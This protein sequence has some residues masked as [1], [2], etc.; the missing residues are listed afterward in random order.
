MRGLL[1]NFYIVEDSDLATTNQTP[2]LF[3][4]GHCLRRS[5][6]LSR[7]KAQTNEVCLS[8]KDAK[9]PRED[10]F[11][12]KDENCRYEHFNWGSGK[13]DLKLMCNHPNA[14]QEMTL[15]GTY[16]PKSYSMTMTMANQGKT[17]EEQMKM[18][19]K[20]DAKNVGQCSVK[21]G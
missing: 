7:S 1:N 19:M 5:P 15:A 17:P 6:V 20:V 10:F 16:E 13:I 3:F 11:T 9:S 21:Q 2:S 8:E 12:G 14:H 4:L 18:T